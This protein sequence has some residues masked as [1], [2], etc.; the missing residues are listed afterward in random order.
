MSFSTKSSQDTRGEQM[1]LHMN[2]A[3]ETIAQFGIHDG[4]FMRSLAGWTA[5]EFCDGLIA[6]LLLF[7]VGAD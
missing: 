7:V 3:F 1:S 4:E 6:R 5:R 2:V